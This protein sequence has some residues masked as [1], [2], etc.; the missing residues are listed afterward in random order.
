MRRLRSLSEAASAHAQSGLMCHASDASGA[1]RWPSLRPRLGL[2]PSHRHKLDT[3]RRVE[4]SGAGLLPGPPPRL[5]GSSPERPRPQ[6]RSETMRSSESRA[7]FAAAAHNTAPIGGCPSRCQVPVTVMFVS[8]VCDVRPAAAKADPRSP[9]ADVTHGIGPVSRLWR[10]VASGCSRVTA[11]HSGSGPL[12]AHTCPAPRARCRSASS[13]AAGRGAS[14]RCWDRSRH[15][16]TM[17]LQIA[18]K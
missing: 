14:G 18:C 16:F 1:T 6:P 4:N 5:P 11:S 17:R 12:E 10:K 15:Q 7:G 13:A 2:L 3:E 9:Y 8:R